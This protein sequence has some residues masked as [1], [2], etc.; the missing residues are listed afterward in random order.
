MKKTPRIVVIGAGPA[1]LGVGWRLTELGVDDFVI[2]EKTDHVGG[3]ATSYRDGAG[4]TWDVGG[5]VLHSHYPYFDRMFEEVMQ[6]DYYTHERE[7]WVWIY[8]RFVPYPFQNNIH[9]L[10]A[11]VLQECLHGLREV[12]KE[13]AG[14]PHSF[15]EWS[16]SLYGKGIAKH[17]LL[18]YN[19]KVWAYPPE[20][21]SYQWVADRVASVDMRRVEE[22]IKRNRDDVS[23][24]PNAV[25]R[26]PKNGGTG[27]IWNRVA[28]RF[29]KNIKLDHEVTKIN[30]R[31]K[32]IHFSDGTKDE[33]DVLFTTIPLDLLTQ[34]VRGID[35]PTATPLHHSSVTIVGIGIAGEA[36]LHLASKCWMYF[37]QNSAPFFRATVFSHYSKYN[38]P[39][40]SWS[41]MT[42]IASSR[43][44][45]LP[46][47]DI[48]ELALE[49]AR[50]TKL[51]PKGSKIEDLWVFHSEYGYPTPTLGRD[52]YLQ[53][54]LPQ[55]QRFGIFS[56]GRFGGWKYEVSNQDH[57]FMQGV[58]WANHVV[59]DEEE[60]TIYQP[61]TVNKRS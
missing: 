48:G 57:A 60:I 46:K 23:W 59:L 5:H 55:L 4:F 2:Y 27:E 54:V 10:P 25:F 53:K 51:M 38:A 26:F 34:K 41:L 47:G 50:H 33:F 21:M 49:G 39:N 3:L 31:E 1:G 44:V 6:G 40:G 61:N 36:P 20:K 24:G 29:P 52:L 43:Y 17:F 8:N 37:P 58:E 13:K 42:E 30:A 14:K 19:R 9:R 15:A 11:K 28:E 16:V 45:R 32:T 35:L 22:N 12:A 18:P 56:R 7:S